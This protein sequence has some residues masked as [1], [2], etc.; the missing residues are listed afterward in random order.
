MTSGL[1]VV[2]IKAQGRDVADLR[3]LI[4][5]FDNRLPE[6]D[7]GESLIAAAVRVIYT[8]TVKDEKKE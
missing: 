6:Y 1:S 7:D 3:K 2:C 8:L 5:A 4:N